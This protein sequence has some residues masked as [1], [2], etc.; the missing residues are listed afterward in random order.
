MAVLL[1]FFFLCSTHVTA[2]AGDITITASVPGSHTIT[3]DADGAEVFCDGAA[4]SSFTVE[5]L[6]E[7]KLLIRA[8]SGREITEV[9]LN[10]E[11]I[12]KQI[13]GGYYAL[14]PVYEDQTLTV[15]TAGAPAAQGKTYT[16]QGTVMRNGQ[17]VSGITMELRSTL[18][19]S[20]TDADGR[21]SFADVECGKHSL[22]ALENGA[23]VGYVEFIL[24]EGNQVDLSLK[25]GVYTVNTNQNAIGIDLVLTLESDNTMRMTEAKEV[26]GEPKTEP[27]SNGNGSNPGSG[28]SQSGGGKNGSSANTKSPKT[29]DAADP[30]MWFAVLLI[31][32][33]VLQQAVFTFNRKKKQQ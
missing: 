26:S 10:G 24:L 30:M 28:G 13:R 33:A 7:P 23:I 21:F 17:P 1:S 18:K 11:N 5:R 31:S 22:T 9:L 19:T 4:G 32:G 6:S 14:E 16:V 3:V 29:G 20:V 15:M 8:E 25:D 2:F 12:T 27:A